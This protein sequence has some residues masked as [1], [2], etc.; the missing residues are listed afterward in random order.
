MLGAIVGDLVGRRFQGQDGPLAHDFPF[1]GGDADGPGF[2]AQTVATIAVMDALLDS[3]EDAPEVDIDPFLRKWIA[4]YPDRGFDPA[5]A[6]WGLDDTAA[7]VRPVLSDNACLARATPVAAY[8][9]TPA[10]MVRLATLVT[11]ATHATP[12]AL[13]AAVAVTGACYMA[14]QGGGRRL[15]RD[16]VE[17]RF[18]WNLRIR[19]EDLAAS[20]PP[21]DATAKET[22]RRGIICALWASAAEE[23]I[24]NAVAL[25]GETAATAAVAGAVSQCLYYLELVNQNAA[26]DR[27]ET[28]LE[29]TAMLF[30]AYT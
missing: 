16:W 2:G 20:V 23:A 11:R 19:Y 22:A 5:V 6:K 30:R 26:L 7:V 29:S 12:E 25:G 14:K 15:V 17:E 28:P 18:G 4:Q 9:K 3:D 13:E 1:W 10:D 8:V 27:L 21:A 24:R